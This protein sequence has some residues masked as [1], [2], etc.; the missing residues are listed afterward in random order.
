[1]VNVHDPAYNRE[2]AAKELLLLEGHLTNPGA[3][4]PECAEKHLVTAEAY[5]EEG[6]RLGD[7]SLAGYAQQIRAIRKTLLGHKEHS[8]QGH[9]GSLDVPELGESDPKPIRVERGEKV[10]VEVFHE[11]ETCHPGSFRTLVP[12]PEHRLTI[13]C[14]RG[15]YSEAEA[16]CLVGTMAQRLE[17]LHPEGSSCPVCGG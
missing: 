16:R 17:H 12:N 3:Y 5:A 15:Q 4:C 6:V 14:P 7:E 10:W 11:S 1:M 9:D 8:D 13:C 2:A